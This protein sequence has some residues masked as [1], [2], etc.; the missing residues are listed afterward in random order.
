MKKLTLALGLCLTSL[1][2]S[3]QTFSIDK[4][5][6][7][8]GFSVVHLSI[9]D[10]EGSFKI[11]D[12]TL[13]AS[14]DDFS[15]AKF[16][17]SADVNTVNT[18]NERRDTHLKSPDFFDAAKF[19]AITFKSKSIT[20]TGDRKFTLAGDLTMHGVTKA[21]NLNLTLN[22]V[23]KNR[24]EKK[25]AGFKVTGTL[26]RTAWGVGSM[27]AA[28]VGEEIEIRAGGEFIQN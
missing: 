13:T 18:D 26:N 7:K 20:K 25:V 11:T 21:V 15:D 17:L 6:S 12:A 9:S 2:A 16:E 14:K 8:L 28:M 24:A 4:A 27:P 19:P 3:A 23:T 1:F 22:G 5:H 10:V